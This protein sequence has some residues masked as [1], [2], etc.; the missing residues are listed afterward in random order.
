M[1][2]SDSYYTQEELMA[3]LRDTINGSLAAPGKQMVRNAQGQLVEQAVPISQLAGQAGLSAPPITPGAASALGASPDSAKMAGTPG[4]LASAIRQSTDSVNTLAE[5][6]ADKRYRSSLTA[7]EQARSDTQKKTQS[8]LGDTA[9]KVRSQIEAEAA[10][11]APPPPTAPAAPVA[12]VAGSPEYTKYEQD[13]S[14]WE[15]STQK[16]KDIYSQI[17][18]IHKQLKFI[19]WRTPA[20]QKKG[21]KLQGDLGD[22]QAQLI[23]LGPKPTVPMITAAPTT[24]V[25]TVKLPTGMV[26]TDPTKQADLEAQWKIASSDPDSQKRLTAMSQVQQL[27][28]KSSQEL[29][30]LAASAAT[31]Q[32]GG[33]ANAAASTV[34][35]VNVGSLF[36]AEG[37]LTDGT[38]L[39]QL[40]SLLKVPEDQLKNMT[41]D[42]LDEAVNA[43]GQTTQQTQ[44][45][46]NNANLGAAER[47]AFSEQAIDESTSGA[48]AIDQ[49]LNMLGSDLQKADQVTFLGKTGSLEELLSDESISKQVT[50]LVT[51]GGWKKLADTDPLKKFITQYQGA[52]TAAADTFSKTGTALDAVTAGN[53]AA[54][55]FGNTTLSPELL[56]SLG[57]DVSKSSTTGIDTS[58]SNLLRVAKGLPAAEADALFNEIAANPSLATEL[59][60]LSTQEIAGLG[61]GKNGPR[62]QAYKKG[63]E[64]WA[65]WNKFKPDDIDGLLAFTFD[66]PMSKSDAAAAGGDKYRRIQAGVTGDQRL[67]ILDPDGDGRLGPFASLRTTIEKSIGP[68]NLGSAAAGKGVSF[69]KREAPPVAQAEVTPE[70]TNMLNYLATKPRGAGDMLTVMNKSP[71]NVNMIRLVASSGGPYAAAAKTAL[72]IFDRGVKEKAEAAAASK[73]LLDKKAEVDK[74]TAASLKKAMR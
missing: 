61:I 62:W 74:M 40:S 49:Q 23:K 21:K 28:G 42:Q 24:N 13:L 31:E 16:N 11:L 41:I 22:R 44:Q 68:K 32:L 36:N 59:N 52:L 63:Q 3:S 70:Q 60:K 8:A 4:Q 55:T 69:T 64:N 54:I 56:A 37:K 17:D 7:D 65:A 18:A 48:A 50:D 45:Q 58:K 39:A 9:S 46:S 26:P 29:S 14:S 38:T 66:P 57:I 33:A 25:V 34:G 5:A 73:A 6:Q 30:A 71:D 67:A 2:G 47:A 51:S 12:A 10:K 1:S 53:K 19:D 43:L 72:E 27:T 15:T 20:G 35:T